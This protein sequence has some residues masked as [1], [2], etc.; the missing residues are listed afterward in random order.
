MKISV[1]AIEDQD[2][3]YFKELS[4]FIKTHTSKKQVKEIIF[5]KN[6][7]L[8]KIDVFEAREHAVLYVKK[9]LSPAQKFD[10][11]ALE[12]KGEILYFLSPGYIPPR[13]F[14][15]RI[16]EAVAKDQHACTLQAKWIQFFCKIL[17]YLISENR[18]IA[19]LDINNLMVKKNLFFQLNGLRNEGKNLRLKTFLQGYLLYPYSKII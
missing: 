5:V 16:L 10:L 4:A 12:A 2:P 6:F 17:A 14:A 18:L 1:I 19:R 8:K 13:N 15:S 3:N 11:G 7:D 9:Y